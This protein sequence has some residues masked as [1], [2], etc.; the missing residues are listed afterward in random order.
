MVDLWR[1]SSPNLQTNKV[2]TAL[3]LFKTNRDPGLR[4]QAVCLI[5]LALGDWDLLD[6]SVEA[7]T[8]YE[9]SASLTGLEGAV[10][11]IRETVRPAFPSTHALL[12]TELSRL[13][14]MLEDPS[15]ELVEKV[16]QFL[17][18]NSSATSDFHYLTVLS[19]L[20]GPRST[21]HTL[22]TAT[23]VVGLD[24]KLQGSQLRSHQNLSVRLGEVVGGLVRYDTNLTE[25]ILRRAEFPRP[26]HL[27]LVFGLD[28]TNR[29]RAANAYLAAIRQNP[30]YAW[31]PQ[32]VELLG[33]LPAGDVRP[34]FRA[35]WTN[36]ALRDSLLMQ[37]SREPEP[38]DREKFLVGLDSAQFHVVRS[39]VA[40]LRA[41]PVDDSGAHLLPVIRLLSRLL[42]NP[43]EVLLR[44]EVVALFRQQTG[45]P[46]AVEEE[47]RNERDLRHLYQPFFT[48]FRGRFPELSASLSADTAAADVR[49]GQALQATR[50]NG[51]NSAR[52]QVI[53]NERGCQ[54]CHAATTRL[55]PSLAGVVARFSPEDLLR[56]VIFPNRNVASDYRAM[57]VKTR[58]GQSHVGFSV[59]ESADVLLLQTG[60]AA[61]ERL[62]PRNILS[63]HV[64]N[65]SLMPSGLLDGVNPEGLADLYAYLRTLSDIATPP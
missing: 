51:G 14:A 21:N 8:A 20:P 2:E 55:G 17:V 10:A 28:S 39:S 63:R 44:K 60:P 58:D 36:Y 65:S 7:H 3:S 50:W 35:Q 49:W 59:F 46:L 22:R 6:P 40:A 5:M 57:V 56:E 19:R 37:L 13:L 47:E 48:W 15:P 41:L 32:L 42:S 64:S 18:P 27:P 52:G 45:L 23:S 62:D 38:G 24:R 30:N 16:T 31:S 54:T 9:L 11:R 33:L 4:L 26:A 25:A 61:T 43:A 1:S 12:N 29:I 34:L 53:F